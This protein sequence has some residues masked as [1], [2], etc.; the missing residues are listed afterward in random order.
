MVT[1]LFTKKKKAL[2]KKKNTLK[3]KNQLAVKVSEHMYDSWPFWVKP[4]AVVL[5]NLVGTDL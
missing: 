5:M 4:L 2:H 1:Y 3:K